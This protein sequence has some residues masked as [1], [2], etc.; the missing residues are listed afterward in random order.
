MTILSSIINLVLKDTGWRDVDLAP[1]AEFTTGHLYLRR[2]GNQVSVRAEWAAVAATPT[3]TLAGLLPAGFRPETPGG[4]D[5][6][7]VGRD[8]VLGVTVALQADGDVAI[9]QYWDG[10][11]PS[12]SNAVWA[13]EFTTSDA[14]PAALPGVE[15]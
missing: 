7:V 14:W 8:G 15:V 1:M 2:R 9:G 11:D 6:M 5:L 3:P 12:T 4:E 13:V 10:A